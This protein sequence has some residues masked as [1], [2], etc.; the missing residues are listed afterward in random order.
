MG[1]F[2]NGY[3]SCHKIDGNKKRKNP[4]RVRVTDRWEFDEKTGKAV[5][6]YRT[7][8]Y[9][10]TR[11]AGL[12]ALADYNKNPAALGTADITFSMLF[13]MWKEKRDFDNM[14]KQAQRAYRG[15]Y[16][17][18]AP[19]HDMKVAQINSDHLNEIM[20]QIEV[21][22]AGQKLLKTFWNQMFDFALEKDIVFKNY[23][24]FVKTRDK[25]SRT[26]TRKP[27]T[28]EQIQLLWDNVDMEGVDTILI[29]IYTGMRPSELL[30]IHKDNVYLEKRYMTGGIK[31]TAGIDR[32]IPIHKSVLP[33]IERRLQSTFLVSMNDG[34]EM[35][36][37]Y[38]LEYVWKPIKD[39]LELEELTPHCCRHT[40]VTLA[41]E[42]E[43]DERLIKK[44]VGHST[45][46]ITDRYRHSYIET[47]INTVLLTCRQLAE[48]I[49]V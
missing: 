25:D 26:S 22:V 45:G 24:K 14:D 46:E 43:I 34:R 13:D 15:A 48:C 12:Q 2:E 37:R 1:R 32:V 17:H 18:S 31:T 23:S 30:K 41:T 3:G 9:Y 36:Y 38:Y 42:A 49:V 21:G 44:I 39:K 6:K 28:K 10:P 27:F 35:Q 11:K 47:L 4:Y 8:G 20:K 16:K 7:L 19:L 33:L 5:Q 40:F 29:M